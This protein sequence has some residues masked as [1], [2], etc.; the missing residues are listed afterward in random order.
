ME[1]KRRW[2]REKERER[3]DS[4]SRPKG[5]NDANDILRSG[6]ARIFPLPLLLRLLRERL[7]ERSRRES[8]VLADNNKVL[9]KQPAK[10]QHG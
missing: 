3:S 10:R 5:R 7:V 4:F 8:I 2:K 9:I 6:A 1:I